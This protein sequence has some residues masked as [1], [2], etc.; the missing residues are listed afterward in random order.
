MAHG[1]TEPKRFQE[2]YDIGKAVTLAR[3]TLLTDLSFSPGYMVDIVTG[4]AA[5][6]AEEVQRIAFD[7]NTKHYILTAVDEDLDKLASDHFGLKRF[8]GVVALGTVTFSRP[9]QTFGNIAINLAT[10]IETTD[11]IQFLTTENPILT[12]LTVTLDI[13]AAIAG[14]DGIVDA[15]TIVIINNATALADNTI[16]VTNATRTSGGVTKETDADFRA[17][18][19][20]FFE[21]LRRGTLS[22]I[23]TGALF[24]GGVVS[25]VVDESVYPPTVFVADS[26]G[27][28][29]SALTD[30]VKV[31]LDN[32]RAAGI[33]VNVVGATVI[34]Q[35]IDLSVTYVAG[36]DTSM[37]RDAI[38]AAIIAGISDLAVGDT[39]FRSAIVGFV[40]SVE[41]V[42]NVV[43]NDP[44]G[45][46]A[47]LL[48][49]IIRLGE[50]TL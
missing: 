8:V 23:R 46:V 34:S 1:V 16:T 18:I 49:Q 44:A 50:L 36:T 9:T 30:A 42:Q 26:T 43:V 47:P 40:Q 37:A 4:L 48:S 3:T 7:L 5:A 15:G 27:G 31:E 45:D 24:V 28:A 10:I 20:A 22:A 32:W 19:I 6:L 41:G 13:Q 17:R 14:S 33:M 38:R 25:A 39:L 35:D 12:G 2:L 29:T 21:T 11:G